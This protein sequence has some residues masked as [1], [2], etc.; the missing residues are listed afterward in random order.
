MP[1]MVITHNVVDVGNWLQYKAER[2]AAVAALGGSNAMDLVAFRRQ[3]RRRRQ[4]RRG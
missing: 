3:Q 1:K 2:A 4:R